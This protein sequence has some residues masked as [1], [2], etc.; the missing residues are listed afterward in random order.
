MD[1]RRTPAE[2]SA[3]RP[4]KAG[5]ILDT[6]RQKTPARTEARAGHRTRKPFEV[7]SPGLLPTEV[8]HGSAWIPSASGGVHGYQ[9]F[10]TNGS[11]RCR[12]FIL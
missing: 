6:M 1:T 8:Y 11:R 2:A 7:S 12:T 3:R 9:G 4:K 10:P 5:C